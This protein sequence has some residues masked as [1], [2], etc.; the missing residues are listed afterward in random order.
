MDREFCEQSHT[1]AVGGSTPSDAWLFAQALL[2]NVPLTVS[3]PGAN[4]GAK[5]EHLAWLAKVSTEHQRRVRGLLEAEADARKRQ[6]HLEWLGRILTEQ[7]GDWDPAK[8]PRGGYPEN[9]GWF[10]PAGTG[11]NPDDRVLKRIRLASGKDWSGDRVLDVM[12]AE[13]P[14]W[15]PF[16]ERYVTLADA[17]N[18][19]T[20]P[21]TTV[22]IGEFGPDVKD[23]KDGGGTSWNQT[24]HFDIPEDWNDFQ[25]VKYMLNQFADN[26]DVHRLAVNWAT[27]KPE[28]FDQLR[29]QRFRNGLSTVAALAGGYYS[30]LASLAPGGQAAVA[31]WD[32]QNGDHLGAALDLAFM[33]PLGAIAK[34]GVEATGTIAIKAGEKVI[35]ALPLKVIEQVEKLAPDAKA[36]LQTRLRAAETA[37]DAAQIVEKF[38]ATPFDRHHP[39]P[40]FLGGEEEQVRAIIPKSVHDEFHSLLRTELRDAGFRLNIGSP[41]GSTPKWREMFEKN[42]GSQGK[43][44]DAVLKA[45]RAIDMK[46]GTE[47]TQKVWENLAGKRFLYF[48]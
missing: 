48:P 21:A 44:F 14:A 45:S 47:I 2:G 17:S 8:H 43:A 7:E 9:R 42:A 18:R 36:L 38:L 15:V 37:S 20:E 31:S 32:I 10:S 35:A 34:A 30:A 5:R 27:N 12:R 29:A 40:M 3:E 16:V 11:T 46:H 24:I 28:L 1:K 4:P 25:V 23:L 13:A 6:D 19:A 33:L 22:R 39:L 26:D 41:S